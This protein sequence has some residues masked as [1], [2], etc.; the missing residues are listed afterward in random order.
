MSKDSPEDSVKKLLVKEGV[1][2]DGDKPR[3]DLIPPEVLEALATVLSYGASKYDS[4]NWEKGM[5]WG[6]VYSALMRH[7]WAWWKGEDKD[8]ETGYS[9]L[10]HAITNLTFLIAY[11][12]RKV[13][14]DDRSKM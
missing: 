2:F 13:G 3:Y 12:Q 11:E 4:R 10:H 14:Q 7:M 9:H 6:R 1:K 5:S 8:P